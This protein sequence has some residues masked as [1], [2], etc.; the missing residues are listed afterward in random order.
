MSPIWLTLAVTVDEAELVLLVNRI[1]EERD[2]SPLLGATWKEMLVE[3]CKTLFS[4]KPTEML[5]LATKNYTLFSKEEG[6]TT[7]VAENCHVWSANSTKSKQQS[8][9]YIFNELNIS[10]AVLE[11]ELVPQINSE[12]G[13]DE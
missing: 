13:E 8:L 10:P 6:Y 4:E 2:A 11:I 7:Q 1:S 3:V 12:E 9:L 5:Y